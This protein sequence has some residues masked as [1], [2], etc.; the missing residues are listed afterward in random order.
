MSTSTNTETSTVNTLL[1][2]ED[3]SKAKRYVIYGAIAC[4]VITA[5]GISAGMMKEKSNAALNGES[6]KAFTFESTSLKKFTEKKIE[7]SELMNSLGSLVDSVKDSSSLLS[8]N[9]KVFN[10]LQGLEGQQDSLMAYTEKLLSKAASGT[11]ANFVYSK[12]LSSL[13]EDNGE[14][15]K[16]LES[17]EGLK[18]SSYLPEE[19]LNL[20][21][22]R[23]YL[24][25]GK[26][27]NAKAS[28]KLII[29]NYPDSNEAKIAQGYLFQND[30]NL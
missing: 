23:L 15:A 7:A 1:D 6:A 16:A 27:D 2:G 10:Q 9:A 22:A 26:K 8:V 24:K 28:L 12:Q 18:G 20:D 17:L 19:T 21:L 4:L 11:F 29:D 25:L 30:I 14:E 3:E 13:Y 5:I